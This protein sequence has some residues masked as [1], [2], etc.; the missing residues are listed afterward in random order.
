MVVLSY[1]EENASQALE[2]HGQD[3]VVFRQNATLEEYI[4][5]IRNL[6]SPAA[7][8]DYAR[9]AFKAW[10]QNTNEPTL[11]YYSEKM[12]LYL[13]TLTNGTAFNLANF[14]EEMYMGF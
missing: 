1:L 2:L 3:S 12:S 6:Y 10:Q 14:K 4:I 8:K 5:Y 13:E 7:E 9:S 11:I